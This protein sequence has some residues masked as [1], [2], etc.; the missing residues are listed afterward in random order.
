MPGTDRGGGRGRPQR[1]D[2]QSGAGAGR[3]SG[4]QRRFGSDPSSRGGRADSGRADSGRADSGRS[5]SGRSGSGRSGSGRSASGRAG[6]AGGP[7]RNDDR[8]RDGTPNESRTGG[9]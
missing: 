2:G 5:G 3:P 1:R 9:R 8:G 7:R 4:G 6:T